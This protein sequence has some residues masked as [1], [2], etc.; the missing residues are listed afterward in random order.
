MKRCFIYLSTA[1]L[2]IFVW[3]VYGTSVHDNYVY[4][5]YVYDFHFIMKDHSITHGQ[6]FTGWYS[7]MHEHNTGYICVHAGR[8]GSEE[9]AQWFKD[10]A[11]VAV[12]GLVVHDSWPD[13]LNFAIYGDIVVKGANGG[14]VK[15]K[16]IVIGQ[17]HTGA[18]NNWWIGGKSEYMKKDGYY[19]Y[20]ECPPSDGYCA[21]TID[22]WSVTSNADTFQLPIRSCPPA[23]SDEPIDNPLQ[24]SGCFISV[25]FNK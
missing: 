13:K 2:L 11:D 8:H 9:V 10:R 1:I 6:P 19:P 16:D 12:G 15:C 3:P 23:Q 7:G 5:R 24:K 21:A 4:F 14:Y 17:G 20:L 25:I 22:V 18:D